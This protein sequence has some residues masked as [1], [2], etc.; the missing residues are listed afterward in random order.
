MRLPRLSGRLLD[1]LLLMAAT[2]VALPLASVDAGRELGPFEVVMA[3]EAGRTSNG[4]DVEAHVQDVAVLDDVGLSLEPL[5]AATS[6]LR[7]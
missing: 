3:R 4:L 2:R 6:G 1:G 7:V 5:E